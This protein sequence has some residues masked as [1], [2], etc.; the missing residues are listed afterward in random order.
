MAQVDSGT[1]STDT[2]TLATEPRVA[3]VSSAFTVIA[4]YASPTAT[5]TGY[6]FADAATMNAFF[7]NYQLLLAQVR[8]LTATLKTDRQIISAS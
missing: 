1:T 4:T 6:G 5:I 3:V 2:I 8:A 7:A